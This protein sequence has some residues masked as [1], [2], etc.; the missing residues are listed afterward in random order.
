MSST[1][2]VVSAVSHLALKEL[3]CEPLPSA[4][5][6]PIAKPFC[7]DTGQISLF[8]MTCEPSRPLMFPTPRANKWGLPDSHGSTAAWSILSAEASP[9][10]TSPS[11]EK[12][13]AL[14]AAAA[15]YGKST[16]DLL[17]RY[18]RATSSWKTSQLCLDGDF[19]TFSGTWPRSGMIRNGIAYRLPP[20]VRRTYGTGFGSLP[21]HSIP[22][23]TASDHIERKCTSTEALNYE[24]NKS[25]SLDRFVNMWPTATS[26][27]W[28]DGS[29]Q[30]CKNVPTN[31]LLGR[32]I[33]QHTTEQGS[34]N[35]SWVEWLMGFPL[36][37]TALRHWATPSSRKSRKSSERQS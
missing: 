22:T 14:R 24:T 27:D 26:R 10:K 31:S 33:H 35:P 21:T 28:K 32:E 4:K 7:D 18:G 25:V 9:A 6:S 29:A 8:S 20:L 17:A 3:E 2:S 5:S 37:W 30:A 1:Y 16:P 13:S 36:E 11:P 23:P 19:Q 12:V 15:A 34:L